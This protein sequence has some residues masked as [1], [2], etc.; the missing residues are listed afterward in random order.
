MYTNKHT[1][2]VETAGSDLEEEIGV[3]SIYCMTVQFEARCLFQQ[4]QAQ[5]RK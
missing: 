4:A 3:K 5:G 1:A 2:I